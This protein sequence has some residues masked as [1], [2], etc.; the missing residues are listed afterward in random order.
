[1]GGRRL[2]KFRKAR[3]KGRTYI[4]CVLMFAFFRVRQIHNSGFTVHYVL[5]KK[6]PLPLPFMGHLVHHTV[7]LVSGLFFFLE[8]TSARKKWWKRWKSY[9]E[10][11]C[12]QSGLGIK[13]LPHKKHH[14]LRRANLNS[15]NLFLSLPGPKI[16]KRTFFLLLAAFFSL[17]NSHCRPDSADEQSKSHTKK[18]VKNTPCIWVLGLLFET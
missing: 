15:A 8:N 3:E 6:A 13:K 5:E 10:Y 7:A 2:R 4:F 1:M 11:R 16:W 9:S 12:L 14:S 18:T 17:C